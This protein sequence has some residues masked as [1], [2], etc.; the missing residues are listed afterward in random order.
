MSDRFENEDKLV[1]LISR[2][3]GKEPVGLRDTLHILSREDVIDLTW[4]Y[5][6]ATHISRENDD[7]QSKE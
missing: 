2:M 5:L 4:E 6:W 7:T 1:R 3:L